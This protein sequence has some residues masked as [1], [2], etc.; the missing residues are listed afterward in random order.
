MS[1][2]PPVSSAKDANERF[3]SNLKVLLDV[4]AAAA[5]DL[6]RLG[7]KDVA[8]P[9]LIKFAKIGIF[10]L[11]DI[12]KTDIV[13]TFLKSSYAK[14]DRIVDEDLDYLEKNIF[15]FVLPEEHDRDD[16]AKQLTERC[17][18]IAHSILGCKK[19]NGE[20]AVDE[21]YI[22]KVG[23]IL[24]SFIGLSVKYAF[25]L[26]KPLSCTSRS[27]GSYKYTFERE[28]P[29]LEAIGFDINHAIREYDVRNLPTTF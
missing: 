14:W 29:E 1:T 26:M 15:N 4:I 16:K 6:I 19:A 23:V 24:K 9:N 27:D 8:N 28:I 12:G 25:F 2:L 20:Y 22:Q 10:E 21:K 5:S 13:L 17:K 7:Y 3:T 18:E 11:A